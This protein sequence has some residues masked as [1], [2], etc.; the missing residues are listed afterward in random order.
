[1]TAPPQQ[2]LTPADHHYFDWST[3]KQ[4]TNLIQPLTTTTHKHHRQYYQ[5]YD[6]KQHLLEDNQLKQNKT[7]ITPPLNLSPVSNDHIRKKQKLNG[8]GS[9]S[10]NTTDEQNQSQQ[11]VNI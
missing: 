10:L 8:I 7:T 1:M 6:E 9:S 4:P 3:S 2:Q 11:Q 5:H